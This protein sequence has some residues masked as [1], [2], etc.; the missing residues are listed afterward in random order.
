[1]SIGGVGFDAGDGCGGGLVAAA[2]HSPALTQAAGL[3]SASDGESSR[4]FMRLRKRATD[5]DSSMCIRQYG[6]IGD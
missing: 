1:V 6:Q 3:S 4:W 5:V 2:A